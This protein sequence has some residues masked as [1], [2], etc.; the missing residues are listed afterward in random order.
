MK[1]MR[2]YE[3]IEVGEYLTS[4]EL[5]VDGEDMIAFAKNYDPQWFHVEVQDSNSTR[6]G[7]VIA[8][9]IYVAAL[10]R[11]LDHEINGDV[12]YICGV[13]WEK[14]SGSLPSEQETRS[15]PQVRWSKKG[16]HPLTQR[17]V[18]LPIYADLKNPAAQRS[19]NSEVSP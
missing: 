1:N 19:S 10:W 17:V 2:C 8:S 16:L 11:K 9:G 18:S 12:D 7:E 5:V 6:F 14:L 13:C 3:D 15:A 4:S